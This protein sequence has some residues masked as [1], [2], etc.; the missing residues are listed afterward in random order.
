MKKLKNIVPENLSKRQF[1]AAKY[2]REFSSF[3]F[4]WHF[5]NNTRSMPGYCTREGSFE[6][7]D[8]E[9][10][11][12]NYIMRMFENGYLD[13][14]NNRVDLIDYAELYDIRHEHKRDPKFMCEMHYTYTKWSPEYLDNQMARVSNVVEQWQELMIFK[15]S[16]IEKMRKSGA[17]AHR[18]EEFNYTMNTKIYAKFYVKSRSKKPSELEV[19][20][21]S[22]MTLK[23]PSALAQFCIDK[24]REYPAE[25]VDSFARKY[26]E[27]YFNK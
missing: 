11:L 25:Q 24:K 15:Y 12:I 9:A 22:H 21:L 5:S 17:A 4:V 26:A 13:R 1:K 7:Y 14:E 27:R 19:F 18:I 8:K 6:K 2:S 3:M 16:E 23:T 10:V 20:D